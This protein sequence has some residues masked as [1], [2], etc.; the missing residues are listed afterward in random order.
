MGEEDDQASQHVD[1][2]HEGHKGGCHL[3]DPLHPAN[4]HQEHQNSQHHAGDEVGNPHGAQGPGHLE[5]LDPIANA[6]RSQHAEQGKEEAQPA[7]VGSQAVLDIVHRPT[8]MIA[9]GIH[10]PVVNRQDGFG[11]LG[12]NPE[13]RHNPHPEHGSGS[14]DKDGAGHASNVPRPNRGGEGCH[15]RLERAHISGIAFFCRGRFQHQA[16]AVAQPLDR[17][18]AEP[19]HQQDACRSDEQYRGPSPGKAVDR[20]IDRFDQFLNTRHSRRQGQRCHHVF[21]FNSAQ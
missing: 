4:N 13:E 16:E 11:V 9:E 6:E 7:P 2:S 8:H 21:G 5:G 19:Q 10:F 20:V 1:H 15:Q 14:T 17:H 18:E 12:G 3:G